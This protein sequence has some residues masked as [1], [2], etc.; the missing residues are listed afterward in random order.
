MPDPTIL[1]TH[2]MVIGDTDQITIDVTERDG[3]DLSGAS[4]VAY[5]YDQNGVLLKSGPATASGT[6]TRRFVYELQS[7]QNTVVACPGTYSVVFAVSFGPV[8]KRFEVPVV[9]SSVPRPPTE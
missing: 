5:V 8:T 7:G 2:F 6:T 4:A 3:A 1:S 9:V